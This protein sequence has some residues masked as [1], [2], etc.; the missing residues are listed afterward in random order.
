METLVCH[1]CFDNIPINIYDDHQNKCLKMQ[2]EYLNKLSLQNLSNIII[3]SEKQ[4]KALEFALKKSKI[5]SKNTKL[6]ALYR[7]KIRGLGENEFLKA[8]EYIQNHAQVVIH[9]NL[10]RNLGHYINDD[11]YR[12]L[13]EVLMGGGCTDRSIRATWEDKLFNNIYN[14]A[15]PIERVKYGAINLTNSPQGI[16]SCYG[17]GDS[18]FILKNKIKE[19]TTFV[20]GDSSKM[21][22]HLGTFKYCTILLTLIPD[23]LLD[24]LTKI[25]TNQEEFLP[26]GHH[27]YIEVQIHG[28]L[29]FGEDVEMLVV[30]KKYENNVT[31][32]NLVK[33][34][35]QKYNIPY[36]IMI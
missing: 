5:Y 32:M 26:Y 6:N 31:I 21:E 33:Q 22:M 1:I 9:V 14:K 4:N 15:E 25:I 12:N 24:N 19:R 36:T 35:S 8:I 20:L 30:N 10:E 27:E 29:R 16:Q 11:N 18:F 28:P 13:F 23:S 7:F 2:Q 3:Y 17:Y 34:F